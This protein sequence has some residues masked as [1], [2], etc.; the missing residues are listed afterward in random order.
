M[1]NVYYQIYLRQIYDLTRTMVIKSSL[2][3][4][5]INREI[6]FRTGPISSDPHTWKYYMNMAGEYHSTDQ[7]MYVTS[8]DT[9]ETIEFTKVNLTIHR[10]TAD[11]Y[12]YGSRYYRDLVNAYPEQESLILGILN[13]V[14]INK[15]IDSDDGVIL[16]YDANLVEPQEINLI[17]RL[18]RFITAYLARWSNDMYADIDEYFI[19]AQVGVLASQLP[20]EIL[21][22]RLEACFTNEA[23]SFHIREHLA[24]NGEMD[25]FMSNMTLK[26]ILFLYRNIRYLQRNAGMQQNFNL[27]LSRF[28][29]DRSLPLSEYQMEHNTFEL[30]GSYVPDIEMVRIPLNDHPGDGSASR[31]DIRGLLSRQLPVARN[32][33]RE[34]DHATPSTTERMKYSPSSRLRSKTL[35]SALID[36]TDSVPFTKEETV[37]NNWIYLATHDRFPATVGVDDPVSGVYIPLSS[38]DA[39]LVFIY[40]IN[41]SFGITLTTIPPLWARYVQKPVLPSLNEMESVTD[42]SIVYPGWVSE[43]KNKQP[44]MGVYISLA[45]FQEFCQLQFIQKNRQRNIY[46]QLEDP[47]AKAQ[48]ES[49]TMLLYCDVKCEVDVG[50]NYQEWMAERGFPWGNLSPE[51]YDILASRIIETV[52]GE[53]FGVEGSPLGALQ[54]AMLGVMR[55]LSSYSVHYLQSINTTAYRIFDTAYPRLHALS[56]LSYGHRYVEL[57]DVEFLN[58]KSSSSHVVNA[59]RNHPAPLNTILDSGVT[60]IQIRTNYSMVVGDKVRF[61]DKIPQRQVRPVYMEFPYTTAPT[62]LIFAQDGSAIRAIDGAYIGYVNTD[63][64]E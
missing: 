22:C 30:L 40:A 63:L 10:A 35:E 23:H 50:E 36:T 44:A 5:S 19:P 34:I 20:M 26:Q 39:L 14:D 46:A 21:N 38:S 53:V 42:R 3:A 49:A 33:D 8:M 48:L 25:R 55:A 31:R 28:M 29:N 7:T 64:D 57:P 43:I 13:P 6:E 27:L 58:A 12:Q 16:Y 51:D 17:P 1:S 9:L 45:E 11:A 24:S 4:D 61:E 62:H 52:A 47:N 32:N 37:I 54:Q 2:V 60:N 15:A 59:R 18:Q 41:R 56:S